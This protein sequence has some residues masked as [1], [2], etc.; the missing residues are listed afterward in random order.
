MRFKKIPMG[1]SFREA[2]SSL[3]EDSVILEKIGILLETASAEI[4]FLIELG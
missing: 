2:L 1:H 4:L 3:K